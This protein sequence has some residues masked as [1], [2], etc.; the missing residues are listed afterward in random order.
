MRTKHRESIHLMS[1]WDGTINVTIWRKGLRATDF[2]R[3]EYKPTKRSAQR[4][5]NTINDRLKDTHNRPSVEIT[6][7]GDT[8]FVDFEE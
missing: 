2:K 5:Q 8:I 4:L 1:G 6:L 7:M 3:R